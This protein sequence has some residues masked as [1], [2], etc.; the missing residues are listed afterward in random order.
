[1]RFAMWIPGVKNHTGN[2]GAHSWKEFPY[3]LGVQYF[4]LIP[5][6]FEVLRLLISGGER[7]DRFI[8]IGH[9][10]YFETGAESLLKVGRVEL[11]A[12]FTESP[13]HS[14]TRLDAPFGSRGRESQ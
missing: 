14:S 8:D 2:L 3:R 10:T 12:R 1:M 13:E 6:L 4:D 5:F 7:R 9:S 11:E